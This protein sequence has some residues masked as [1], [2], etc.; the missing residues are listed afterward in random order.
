MLVVGRAAI[1]SR[2]TAVGQQVDARTVAQALAVL[3]RVGLPVAVRQRQLALAQAVVDLASDDEP[4]AGDSTAIQSPSL[5]PNASRSPALISS[6]PSGSSRRQAGSR[7]IW[8]ALN[9][10]RCPAASMNGNPSAR[11]RSRDRACASHSSMRDR[12][13]NLR[14]GW[15]ISDQ[16]SS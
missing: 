8:L 6:A 14:S 7:K 4:A 3:R 1:G 10:R 5:A 12:E 13:P 16:T 15:L 2:V 11:P 9:M